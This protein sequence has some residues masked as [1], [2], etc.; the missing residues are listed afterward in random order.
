M[1]G[2]SSGAHDTPERFVEFQHRARIGT[3]RRLALLA[4][5]TAL[6][7][8]LSLSLNS[9]RLFT[10]WQSP[11]YVPESVMQYWFTFGAV[12]GTSLGLVAEFDVFAWRIRNTVQTEFPM[13]FRSSHGGIRTLPPPPPEFRPSGP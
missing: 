9:M 6:L 4:V 12:M 10:K 8:W 11:S 13:S 7:L 2:A 1:Y 3:A 5:D